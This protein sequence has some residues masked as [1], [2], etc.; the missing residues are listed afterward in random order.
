MSVGMECTKLANVERLL[1]PYEVRLLKRRQ[2]HVTDKAL[3]CINFQ[4]S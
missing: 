4:I 3:N 2:T 1:L